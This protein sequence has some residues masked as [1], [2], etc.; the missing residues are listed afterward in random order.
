MRRESVGGGVLLLLERAARRHAVID[1]LVAL[2]IAIG[3]IALA[4]WT[5]RPFVTAGMRGAL[6][7]LIA[8]AA[9]AIAI[10]RHRRVVSARTIAGRLEALRPESQNL[11]VTAE[12]LSRHPERASARMR[13]TVMDRASVATRGVAPSD[14]VPG[15]RVALS[16]AGAVFTM[17]VASLLPRAD[18]V[19][20]TMSALVD[21]VVGSDPTAVAPQL[22]VTLRPP[23]Y[24]NS[25]ERRMLNPSR[26]EVV[27][28][29]RVS[30]GLAGVGERRV[31]SG[32]TELG[33]VRAGGE[34]LEMIPQESAYL[35]V[36]SLS[37]DTRELI[38]LVVR[39][40]RLP[41]VRIEEPA[42]DLLLPD[43]GRS[44]P[45]RIFAADDHGLGSLEVRYTTM[46]GAGERF[47]FR[48]GTVPLRLQRK[49]ASEWHAD[50]VLPLKELQLSAGDS[51]VYQALAADQR[52]GSLSASDTYFVEISGPG[53]V[54]FEAIDMRPDEDRYAFSQ[55]MIVLKTERLIGRQSAQTRD[56]TREDAALIAAEQRTVRANFVFLLGGHVEDEEVEAEQ[57]SEIS[58]GRLLNKARRDIAAAIGS[59]TTAEQGLTAENLQ[60]ALA[61]AR[62]AVTALQ[63]AFGASRYLLRTLPTRSRIDPSRRLSGP[64]VA[65][66]AWSRDPT[67]SA[68]DATTAILTMYGDTLKL[69]ETV[70]AHVEMSGEIDELAE[71]A[72][73]MGPGSAVWQDVS[74]RLLRIRLLRSHAD[75]GR[76][77]DSILE[78]IGREANR[79]LVPRGN[80][81]IGVLDPRR[82]W[83]ARTR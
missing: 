42:R 72:L 62:D 34:P 13:A 68:S 50:G 59:M 32:R 60:A 54:A 20:T 10:R 75:A 1:G 17:I 73:A 31:R 51:V 36:E 3:T 9:A 81:A 7:A 57:S 82:A 4:D 49:S 29:T 25:P 52:A 30:V 56:R 21:R 65:A 15:R 5:V 58:E 77:L 45:L 61:A 79:R 22:I 83:E 70:S 24:L 37:G 35:A 71:R 8:A 64:L 67:S 18:R 63:R 33:V 44:V 27:H 43:A 28:G 2:S 55:Q 6:A 16:I 74:Q 76:A 26:I 19:S 47:E 38:V 11:V 12:E 69:R 41:A 39:P 48:E 46:S 78:T 53:Q 40:D 23:A 80:P 66:S 14:V